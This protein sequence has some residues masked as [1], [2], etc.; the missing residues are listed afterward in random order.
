M[1]SGYLFALNSTENR[2]ALGLDGCLQVYKKSKH[3]MR[4]GVSLIQEDTKTVAGAQKKKLK[5]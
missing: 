3:Q 4:W 5:T 1:A 2:F